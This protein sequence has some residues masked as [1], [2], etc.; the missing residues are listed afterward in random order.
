VKSLTV[1]I[2]P[3]D[4]RVAEIADALRMA[5][6]EIGDVEFREDELVSAPRAVR[7]IGASDGYELS[8]VDATL[9]RRFD[10]GDIIC[11]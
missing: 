5:F 7:L 6:P 3:N 11:S 1:V 10:H 9:F 4:R 2:N 8:R